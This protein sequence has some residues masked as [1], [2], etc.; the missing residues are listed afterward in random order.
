M[1]GNMNGKTILVV[2]AAA[3]VLGGSALAQGDGGRKVLR[4]R[5]GRGGLAEYLGLTA[6]QRVRFEAARAEHWKEI[7]PLRAEGRDLHGRLRSALEARDPDPATVGKAMLAVKQH[8]ERMKA[9]AEAFRARMKSELTPEQQQKFDAFE[10]ARGVG[11]APH[12]RRG[13]RP[14]FPG[15]AEGLPFGGPDGPPPFDDDVEGPPAF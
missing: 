5:G 10:A 7:E 13:P 4:E 3:G 8:G 12:G 1:N 14:A 11:R 9:S 15:G 2:L 6:E